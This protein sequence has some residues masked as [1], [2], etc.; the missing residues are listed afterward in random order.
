VRSEDL[1]ENIPGGLLARGSMPS[2]ILSILRNQGGGEKALVHFSLRC[3]KQKK[4]KK[5]WS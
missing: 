5:R 2:N 4:K 1:A 3:E